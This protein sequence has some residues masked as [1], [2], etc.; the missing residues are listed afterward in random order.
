MPGRTA[1]PDRFLHAPFTRAQLAEAG[2]SDRIV[3]GRRFRRLLPAVW[4]ATDHAVTRDDLILAARLALPERAQMSH[5]TRIEALGYPGALPG[6]LHFTVAGDLHLAV[7]GVVLHRTEVLPP[8]DDIG[9]TPAAAFVQMCAQ[10]PVRRLV[11]VGDWLLRH[12]HASTSEIRET[13][14]L[15]RWRPGAVGALRVVPWLNDNSWA[16]GES[17]VR[18]LLR[19]A[20]LPEPE[21][22]VRLYD[23]ESFL[24]VTDLWLER[25]RLALEVEGE[26]HFVD[27][28]Q[29]ERDVHRYASFRQAGIH[30]LQITK[31]MRRQPV[32]L[33]HAVDRELRR[34]GYDGPAVSF[35]D[36][37]RSLWQPP[38]A[39]R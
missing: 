12:E 37:W 32:A 15:H 5:A 23:G 21:M 2:I 6:P 16:L 10:H 29:I 31:T 4:V 26:Q 9:V 39:R 7:P 24:G 34:V 36:R 28:G 17:E 14:L 30:Y 8:C 25:W 35:G 13:A 20:G 38:S 11:Q 27:P 3:E 22:N 33:V 19:A 18:I 1:L